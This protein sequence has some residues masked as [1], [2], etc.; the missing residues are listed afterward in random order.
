MMLNNMT[1]KT[2]LDDP[3]AFTLQVAETCAQMGATTEPV[4]EHFLHDPKHRLLF[5]F[6]AKVG[7]T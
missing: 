3:A 2:R 1:I 7:G 4:R 5:C 6:N